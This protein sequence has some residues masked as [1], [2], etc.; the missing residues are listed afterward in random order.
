MRILVISGFSSWWNRYP[1]DILDRTEGATI[2]G[3]EEAFLE[4]SAQLAKQG[5]KV[6]AYHCGDSG[7]WRGVEF[8]GPEH[9]VYPEI[10]KGDYDALISWSALWPFDYVPTEADRFGKKRLRIFS[11][12]L[13]DLQC[14]GDW[15]KVDCIISPSRSHADFLRSLGWSG[16]QHVVHNGLRPEVYADKRPWSERGMDVG[17]WNSPDRGLHHILNA[18][19]A[20]TAAIPSARLHVFYE[21]RKYLDVVRAAPIGY[22]GGRGAA[23]ADAVLKAS[24]DPSII[25]HGAVPR[26]QLAKIQKQCRVHAYPYE[27]FAYCEGF[28]GSVNQGLAAGCL[29]ITSPLDALPSLYGDAC[30]WITKDPLDRDYDEHI[31]HLVIDGLKHGLKDQAKTLDAAA[32]CW[33]KYTWDDAGWQIGSAL[34]PQNW[35]PALGRA[36]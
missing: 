17:Y 29:V 32:Q 15:G 3:G 10:I 34:E 33:K 14:A 9:V 26:L 4:T 18:W 31:A 22:Y 8:R 11:Q 7:K 12:Q 20:V 13:N 35:I 19:P 27:P 36:A 30:H 1:V 6:I 2:G 5:H 23:V 16:P 21:V 25:M 28:C 24:A